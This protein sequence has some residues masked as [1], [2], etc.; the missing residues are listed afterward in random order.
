MHATFLKVNLNFLSLHF[1]SLAIWKP[2][3][4]EAN[5]TAASRGEKYHLFIFDATRSSTIFQCSFSRCD[6][7]G[8]P[9]HAVEF[10]FRPRFSWRRP[11]QWKPSGE[12]PGAPG[13]I[14]CRYLLVPDAIVDSTGPPRLNFLKNSMLHTAAHRA[15]RP[16]RIV[17][18]VKYGWWCLGPDLLRNALV[19]WVRQCV[20]TCVSCRSARIVVAHLTHRKTHRE[21]H[22]PFR[23]KQKCRSARTTGTATWDPIVLIR[24]AQLTGKEKVNFPCFRFELLHRCFDYF[25]YQ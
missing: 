16:I 8:R 13:R 14:T 4:R 19:G 21:T 17:V 6:L 3:N 20:R 12:K 7:E 1:L 23:S 22:G 9:R 24:R 10:K 18:I 25:V 2:S 5:V 15:W 11:S